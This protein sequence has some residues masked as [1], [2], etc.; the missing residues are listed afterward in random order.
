MG[1]TLISVSGSY[2]HSQIKHCCPR[3]THFHYLGL[4]HELTL[5]PADGS[6]GPGSPQKPI[7]W[8]AEEQVLKDRASTIKIREQRFWTDR[9]NCTSQ[10]ITIMV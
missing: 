6:H 5:C 10:I 9:N 7:V 2:P 4:G 3:V 8:V 1:K